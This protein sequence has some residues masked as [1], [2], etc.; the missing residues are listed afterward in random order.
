MFLCKHFC[1]VQAISQKTYLKCPNGRLLEPIGRLLKIMKVQIFLSRL[2]R[3]NI[4]PVLKTGS[5]SLRNPLTESGSICPWTL[6]K[7]DYITEGDDS[8]QRN[9]QNNWRENT[10]R[11]SRYIINNFSYSMSN[12]LQER[13]RK[14]AGLEGGGL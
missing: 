13:L 2:F 6:T 1:T 7:E 5:G 3:P 12:C 8:R 9:I 11:D 14:K 4:F 10:F